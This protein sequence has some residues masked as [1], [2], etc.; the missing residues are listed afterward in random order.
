MEKNAK[1]Y[2]S[3]WHCVFQLKYHLVLVIKYRKSCLNF[4]ILTRLEQICREQC[5]GWTIELIEFSGEQDHIHL[6]LDMHPNMMPSRFIN[7][8]KTVT[9]R[10]IRKEF[11]AHL[12]QYYWKPIL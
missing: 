4:K 5:K 11:S 12:D 10:L 3:D 7:S 9:S 6:L 2:K 1:S 8:L